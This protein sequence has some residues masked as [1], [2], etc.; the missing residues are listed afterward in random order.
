MDNLEECFEEI[1]EGIKMNKNKIIR[2]D[3]KIN[4]TIFIEQYKI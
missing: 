4:L 1:I 3:N 2:E